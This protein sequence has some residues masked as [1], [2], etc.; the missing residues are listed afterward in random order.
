MSSFAEYFHEKTKYTPQGIARNQ[1]A[2]DW[3]RQPLSYKEYTTTQTLD[4][5]EPIDQ[6]GEVRRLSKLLFLSYGVTAVIPY[7]NQPFYMRSAPSAGGLYPAEVYLLSRGTR[8]IPMGIYNYQV[9][10]HTLRHYWDKPIFDRLEAACFNHPALE[11]AELALVIT[12][13]FGRSQWRYEDRAY[14]RVCL[15]TGHLL[16]NLVLA[17]A[18]S[19]FGL[20]LIGGFHDDALAEALFLPSEEEGPLCVA[21]LSRTTATTMSSLA[22]PTVTSYPLVPTGQGLAYLHQASKITIPN[23]PPIQS[24][25]QDKYNFPFC[26][27]VSM[28][29]APIPWGNELTDTIVQRRSTRQFSGDELTLEELKLLLHFTYQPQDYADQGHDPHPNYFDVSLL[30]TFIAVTA[31]RGL[32]AGC[33]YYA[34][35]TQELR[36]IRFKNFRPEIHYLCLGQDLGR[37]AGA[38]VFHTSDL[39]AA[40]AR[41]GERAYRYLHLD[42]GHLG[43]RLNLAATRLGLGVSGIAGF[44]DDQ[45]NEV[46][47]IP[48]QEAVLYIT[49]LGRPGG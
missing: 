4:L 10:S 25:D 5:R 26:L 11:T 46:L 33:Y 18:L 30:E 34:P 49:T 21:A 6:T 20:H 28:A 38:V 27:K 16:G 12:G 35:T 3:S 42:A 37:D 22:S 45:V 2:L 44:F 24:K 32:E 48:E 39:K 9:L 40:V 19:S 17:A 14:R 13:V 23:T 31:V 15:D 1:R 29:T 36:Q 47:G 41:Y 8:T 7:P 43:Q